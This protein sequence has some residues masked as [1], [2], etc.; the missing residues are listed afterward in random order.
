L[1]EG[2][3]DVQEKVG[4]DGLALSSTQVADGAT[5]GTLR[6]I[7]IPTYVPFNGLNCQVGKE[8]G[9]KSDLY[10]LTHSV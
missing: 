4:A 1:W 3:T 10:Q 8:L 9:P 6:I 2:C 5:D 7:S